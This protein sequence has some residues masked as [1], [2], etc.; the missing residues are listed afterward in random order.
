VPTHDRSAEDRADLRGEQRREQCSGGLA[1]VGP[2]AGVKAVPEPDQPVLTLGIE[3]LR[4][5]PLPAA[6]A[7]GSAPSLWRTSNG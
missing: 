5:E 7:R 3:Q 6:W 1:Q 4:G 2:I